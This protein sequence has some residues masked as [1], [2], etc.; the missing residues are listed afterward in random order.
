MLFFLHDLRSFTGL[1]RTLNATDVIV[2]SKKLEIAGLL[3]RTDVAN[4][5]LSTYTDLANYCT[6]KEGVTD[7]IAQAELCPLQYRRE[8]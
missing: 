1:W 8:G 7:P 3:D 2:A 4:L 5:R 6:C